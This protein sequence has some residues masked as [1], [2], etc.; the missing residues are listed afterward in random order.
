MLRA[1]SLALTAS[2]T[3]RSLSRTA[4][5]ASV[6]ELRAIIIRKLSCCVYCAENIGNM[7][8][9]RAAVHTLSAGST[10]DKRCCKHL[11]K[12]PVNSCLVIV[13]KRL[14]I[15]KCRKIIFNLFLV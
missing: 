3:G 4:C 2:D 9:L 1:D 12:H 10:A 13:C 11:F 8:V 14:K 15:R 6:E 5:K 7:Y